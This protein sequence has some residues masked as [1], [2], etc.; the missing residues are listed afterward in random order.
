LALGRQNPTAMDLVALRDHPVVSLRL[1]M[2]M[3]V[4]NLSS[5][6]VLGQQTMDLVDVV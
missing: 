4:M 3:A 6:S 5:N 1:E 2:K